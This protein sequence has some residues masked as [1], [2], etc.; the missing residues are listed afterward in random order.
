MYSSVRL[1]FLCLV[2][3][4]L[5][6]ALGG[7][8]GG[9]SPTGCEFSAVF[10]FG[11]SNSDTG[12]ISAALSEV[13]PP[14]GETFF[15]HP[16]GRFCDGRLIVDFIAEDL[17]LPYLSAYLDSIETNF[18]HGAN[19]ATGGSSIRPGG[20]S[21]FHLGIQISQFVR[22]KS[23][24]TDLYN[25]LNQSTEKS[26]AFSYRL[27]RPQ[28]FS[29]ALYTFD[30]GQNDLA[31]GFQ[32]T[33]VEQVIASI[34]DILSQ[35]S[36]AVHQLYEE[37]ARVFWVHNTGPIGCLPY[38]I[39]YDQSKPGN[40]DQNGCVRPQ[41]EVAEDFN[42]QLK[43]RILQ[44]RAQLSAA[45]FTYV[46]VYSAKYSLISEAKDQG[47]VDPSSFCC[48]SYYGYHI[49]CGKKAIVNGTVYGN[50]CED[51]SKHIS[52]DGIHYSEAANKWVASRI[53]SG[54][55][56]YPAVSIK[57]SCHASKNP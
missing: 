33:T 16:S 36:R 35:F 32:H 50:P 12:A 24:V 29:K 1:P 37:G 8:G 38:S 30:I 27:P 39:I 3:I 5:L 20:Y 7:G 25:R 56:S 57:K 55:F 51:P 4:Q 41:N 11:D 9:G 31:Y 42:K 2:L 26:S 52:W 43:D 54:F 17:K 18:G 23:R 53:L 46:D 49:D 22:F 19:F 28:D 14:N 45:V 47:F 48:G 44:L 21:P 34:P 13:A 6:G 10:N 15:G 40:L